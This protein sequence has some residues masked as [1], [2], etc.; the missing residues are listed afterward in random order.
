MA[1]DEHLIKKDKDNGAMN[2]QEEN[3]NQS[4]ITLKDTDHT[5]GNRSS[6][7]SYLFAFSEKL[8][9]SGYLKW[10]IIA[11]L[12]ALILLK[13]PVD[14]VD[15]DL[16][17]QMA[18]GK[19]Y[20]TH[21]TL[22]MDLSIFSWTPTDPTWIYNTCL[23]SIVIYLFYNFMGGFGLW[24]FQW[25]IFLGV[26]L[27]Y[28]LFLRLARQRLDINS[29]TLIAAIGIA[30]SLACRFYKPE[31]FSPLLFCWVVFIFFCVKITRRKFLFYLYPLIFALWVNL[32]GA[33]VV[34]LTF[35]ALAFLGELL[36][37]IFFSRESWTT[38]ELIHLGVAGILSG[39]ATL[40]NPYGINYLT[41]LFP[42]L[43]NAINIQN[44]S[45]PYDK[46]ILAYVSLWPYLRYTG[47]SFFNAGLTAWIMTVM[48]ISLLILFIYELV[49]KRSF[50]FTL[51]IL[52]FALYWKGM[53]T[54]RACYFF[55][56]AFFF[57]FLYLQI[58]R[59]KLKKI[60]ARATI[61]SLLVFLFFF[62]SIS[63]YTIRF[64]TDSKWFGAGID[65]FVPVKEVAFLK[66]CKLEG[67]VFN[68]YVIGGYL[69]WDLYPD[70]KVFIDPRG[71]LYQ[72]RVFPD[73]ME[74]TSKHVTR[75]DIR[76][77][78]E[79]YPF[80]IVIMHYRQL[81]LIFE[82]LKAGDEWRLLYFE[83]NAAILIHKSLLPA[84]RSKM[85]DVDLSPLRF[86]NVKNPEILLNVFNF[87]VRLNPQAGRYIY[88]VFKKNVSDCY[89]PKPDVLRVMDINI[90]LKEKALQNKADGL[91]PSVMQG[92]S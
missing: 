7:M 12:P 5:A 65:N 43:M 72:N 54:S 44:Y 82:F 19:Y 70:Y 8:A 34:G 48:I 78:T 63:Y 41:S 61:F 83:K 56:I 73:Y 88:Y 24:L 15:Y 4:N 1:A 66:K 92:K 52:S 77:F 59:L 87:Y 27:A 64:G 89:Q 62:V 13:Y 18:H 36:N 32:H 16:W 71:G 81:F 14:R 58:Y 76:Q 2:K 38:K 68:D 21:H 31:L 69:V 3:G 35:L 28:Y 84:V 74:F 53:E 6:K 49:K 29:V 90:R 25:F 57:I 39:A 46:S 67:P 17:W 42:T 20:I 11:L 26:F 22:T 40:L 86:R 23:G 55:P 10:L 30:C 47:I 9:S 51:P 91:S 50:D 60:P 79:K 85:G 33:F 75:E 37:R 45:G 80:K